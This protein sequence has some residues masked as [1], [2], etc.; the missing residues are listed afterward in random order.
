MKW[1]KL[2]KTA[3]SVLMLTMR[4]QAPNMTAFIFTSRSIGTTNDILTNDHLYY[5]SYIGFQSCQHR[6]SIPWPDRTTVLRSSPL[7]VF[8]QHSVPICSGWHKRNTPQLLSH[9]ELNI[10]ATSASTART[11]DLQN[12]LVWLI[13][14]GELGYPEGT[15][16]QN[17]RSVFLV[18]RYIN[19]C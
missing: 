9:L 11:F 1:Q 15:A 6:W 14:D 19:L 2:F 18:Q 17:C 10:G 13:A 8:H 3:V 7:A 5:I 16:T 12:S 4:K